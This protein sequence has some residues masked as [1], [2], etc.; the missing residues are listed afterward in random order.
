M[1]TVC[2]MIL[3]VQL[4][5]EEENIAAFNKWTA[6]ETIF[7][8][9]PLVKV[10]KNDLFKRIIPQDVYM[11]AYNGLISYEILQ[12]W[13]SRKLERPDSFQIMLMDE[14]DDVFTIYDAKTLHDHEYF[15]DEWQCIDRRPRQ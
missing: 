14:D 4:D 12:F 6:E 9:D 3:S 1:S 7:T 2:A 8:Y 10:S 5:C 13:Q 11:L 15:I